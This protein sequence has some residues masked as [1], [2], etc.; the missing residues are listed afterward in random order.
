MNI[1]QDIKLPL[2]GMRLM[3]FCVRK[4]D[5]QRRKKEISAPRTETN[6]EMVF[7]RWFQVS[8]RRLK[9]LEGRFE[10]VTRA[11]RGEDL[12]QV[13][14]QGITRKIEVHTVRATPRMEK[15]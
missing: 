2:E 7:K 5:V 9:A 14:P 10:T 15:S 1:E 3:R 13:E 12:E 6:W 8:G 4:A 11:I